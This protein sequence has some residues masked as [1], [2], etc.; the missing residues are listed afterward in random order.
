MLG[1]YILERISCDFTEDPTIMGSP[2]L[3]VRLRV[4]ETRHVQNT[5]TPTIAGWFLLQRGVRKGRKAR[6]SEEN[7]SI[8]KGKMHKKRGENKRPARMQEKT[9]E[10][11]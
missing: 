1:A 9:N 3:T 11:R 5:E 8:V 2:S 6:E 7:A 10:K 4:G